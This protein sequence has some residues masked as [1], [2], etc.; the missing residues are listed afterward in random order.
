MRN[1]GYIFD[2][3][4]YFPRGTHF[5]EIRNRSASDILRYRTLTMLYMYYG[6]LQQGK[7][8]LC[9]GLLSVHPIAACAERKW[10][11]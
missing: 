4:G 1:E 3:T 2:I 10:C 8:W 9:L 7:S 6:T 11:F 5:S